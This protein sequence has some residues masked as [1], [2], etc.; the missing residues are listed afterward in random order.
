V[1]SSASSSHP[2]H[3]PPHALY[4]QHH[5][6]VA[7]NPYHVIHEPR[8]RHSHLFSHLALRLVAPPSSMPTHWKG[9]FN[10]WM[11][12]YRLHMHCMLQSIYHA[13][14][15]IF[16]I[17]QRCYYGCVRPWQPTDSCSSLGRSLFS[18]SLSSNSAS[19]ISHG[20]VPSHVSISPCKFSIVRASS[21][22]IKSAT[23]CIIVFPLLA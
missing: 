2:P 20:H 9:S 5:D 19:T 8:R 11:A 18:M 17:Q 4:D 12:R 1:L 14:A 23:P 6:G 15:G 13:K 3:A 22:T 7:K 10:P 16:K 21:S